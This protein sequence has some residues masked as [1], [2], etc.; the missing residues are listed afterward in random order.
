MTATINSNAGGVWVGEEVAAAGI[1]VGASTRYWTDGMGSWRGFDRRGR[2]V[3]AVW[4][5]GRPR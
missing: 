3:L 4:H 1:Y 5:P 2:N